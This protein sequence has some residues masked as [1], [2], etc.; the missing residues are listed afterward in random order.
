MDLWKK[1][2]FDQKE[3]NYTKIE[4]ICGP[5]YGS[6][7]ETEIPPNENPIWIQILKNESQIGSQILTT[8][9]D[10]TSSHNKSRRIETV[11]ARLRLGHTNITHVYIYIYIYTFCRVGQNRPSVIDAEWLL[12]WNIWYLSVENMQQ[13][14]TSTSVT[15]LYRM[16][17]QKATICL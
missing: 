10:W 4:D 14:V 17:W 6:I 7:V 5:K 13:Y 11:L 15:L 1:S 3:K 16:C 12:Q 2:V 9:K 8:M